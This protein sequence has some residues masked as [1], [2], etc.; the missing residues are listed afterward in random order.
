M[1]NNEETRRGLIASV[2]H[3]LRTPMTTIAGFVDGILDGTIK[4]EKQEYYLR[5]ISDEIKRLARLANSMLAV[6]RLESGKVGEKTHFDLS[7]MLRRIIIGF[8]QPLSQKHIDVELDI[9]ESQTILAEHDSFFQAVY[10]LIDNA[11]KFTPEGGKITIYLAE[12]N[13]KLQCNIINTGSEIPPEKLKFIFDRFYKGD[14]SRNRNS[15]GAGL[16]LYITK[17]VI[18]QHGGDIFVRSGEGKTEFCFTIPQGR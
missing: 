13:G 7:E 5:I 10:N 3:D 11:V 12:K 18:T 16:G 8:E 6:S 9:P 1:E 17:T 15:S 14:T 2:S 4:P